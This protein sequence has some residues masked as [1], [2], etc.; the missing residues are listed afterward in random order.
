MLTTAATIPD[1]R[2]TAIIPG[3]R[4]S[5]RRHRDF[6][7]LAAARRYMSVI[8]RAGYRWRLTLVATA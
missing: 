6:G 2:I 1:I 3:Q 8:E 5:A 4:I 7:T